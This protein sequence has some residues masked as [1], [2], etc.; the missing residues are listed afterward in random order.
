[1]A[2]TWKP[3]ASRRQAIVAGL[4]AV[5]LGWGSVPPGA[6]EADV[7]GPQ[8]FPLVN[9][10]GAAL[11]DAEASAAPSPTTSPGPVS[12]STTDPDVAPPPSPSPQASG[13]PTRAAGPRVMLPFPSP[14]ANDGG[15]PTLASPAPLASQDES[16]GATLL[17]STPTTFDNFN[18][19]VSSG[20]GTASSGNWWSPWSSCVDN[21]LLVNGQAGSITG[22]V[23]PFCAT[24]AA[25]SPRPWEAPRWAMTGKFRTP[26]SGVWAQLQLRH[27]DRRP[28]AVR[29]PV[30]HVLRVVV[31]TSTPGIFIGADSG[32]YDDALYPFAP[33]TWYSFSWVH[34]WGEQS[35]AKVW[36]SSQSAPRAW[37][38]E[39]NATAD[40]F[41]QPTSRQLMVSNRG[42]ATALVD[43]FAFGDAPLLQL[44]PPPPGTD[45]NPPFDDEAT[46]GD[47]VN[48]LTGTLSLSRLDVAIAGRGPAISFA[49]AYNSND[50]RTTTLG[51]GWTHTYNMRLNDP[52]DGSE[53][54]ILVGPQGRS[55]RYQWSGSAFVAPAGSETTLT[56]NIDESYTATD[57]SQSGWEFGADGRLTSIRDRYGN[58]SALTYDTS[59]RLAT[60]SDPAGRGLLT[61]GYT[62]NL[63]TSV[64]DW[65]SPART[66]TYQYDTNGRLWKAFDREGKTTTYTYDGTSQRLATVTDANGH[67]TLTTTYDAS[68]RAA[69]QQDAR[70]LLTGDITTF[71][72]IANP[73]G[74]RVTT[75]T[76]P[77]TSYEPALHPTLVDTYDANGRLTSR[78]TRPSSTETLTQGF[79]YDA[80]GNRTSA[81]D[82]RGATTNFCYDVD[83]AGSPIAGGAAN[84]T[85][86]IG[87]PPV[88]GASRPVTLFAYDAR[89]NMIQ[90]VAPKGVPSGQTVTCSTNLSAITTYATDV[91]YDAAGVNLL[92][93]TTR[94][95]D[96]DTSAKT[97]VTKYEYG[98]AANP[99]LVTRVIPPR[100]NTG[101]TPDYTYAMTLTYDAT[102]SQAGMPKDTTDPLGNK[103]SYTYDAVGRLVSSVDALGNAAGG[104]PAEHTTQL[105]YDREDRLRFE[106]S[107]APAPGGSPIVRE[108]RYDEVGRPVVR[109]AP[110]GQVTTY[111]YDER[112]SLSQVKES[113][114]A[115]TDPAS[116]PAAVTTT[117]YTHDAGGN[118]TRVTR[119]KGDGTYE[120]ATDS[121]YDGR[122]LL[123]TETQYP[124]WPA[125]SGPLVTA[126]TFDPAG[127]PLTVV[128]ALGQG[129]THG[130][131]AL[132]R[133]ISV[134]Y[135]APGTADVGYAYD[136]NGNRT[137]MTDGTGTT[138]YAY[139]EA[140]RLTSVT[141]PGPKTL[142]YRYDLDGNRTKIVYP[143]GT[144]V[145]YAFDK[146]GRMI[147][148]ADW[149]S[150]SVAYT[151]FADGLVE[152]A[153]NPNATV[154]SY[155]YDNA[156]RLV[157]IRHGGPAGQVLDRL[158]YTL[159]PA[160]TVTGLAN[161]SFAAQFARPDGPA[162]SNG[163]WSG[164]FASINEV[165]PN[166]AT[167]LASPAGPTTTNYYEVSLGD[168]DPPG[169]RAGITV[170][171]RYAKSGNDAGQ[172]I[173]LT[174]ELRQG[175]T[176][177]AS[178]AHPNIPGAAGSG[179]QAGS[180]I[181]TTAQANAITNFAD[182]RL[183]FRPSAAGGGQ[184][185]SAEI[186]WAEL[187]V[188]GPGDPASQ[189]SYTY[190]R[191]ERLTGTTG[192]SGVRGYTYDPVGNR[193][194]KVEGATTTS[195]YD[196]ADRLTAVGATSVAVDAAGNLVAKGADTF[197]FDAA[198]RLTGATV[199]GTN[200]AYAYDGDG[201]RVSRQ[202]GTGPV[203]RYVS[204]VNAPLPIVV[205][206]GSR[207]YIYGLGLAYS[208][209][210]SGIEVYHTD[211]LGSVREL[212]NG[213]GAVTA[214]YRT[215]EWG[216]GTQATGSSSQPF[217][218]TGEPRDGT[219]LTYLRARYYD[220][221]IGLFTSRD[222][223]PGS[224]AAPG[225]LN[226]YAYVD[227]NPT[228]RSD[229]SGH[230]G[231]DVIV[232]VG[233]IIF[234]LGSLAFG[235]PKDREG[236][237]LALGADVGGAAIPCATGLGVFARAGIKVVN[238]GDKILEWE[239]CDPR[240]S[241]DLRS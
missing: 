154:A 68:G 124:S 174:V 6:V 157:E 202:V 170:R 204:D 82:L 119:A 144:A 175:A 237:L 10:G 135:A 222:P 71:D 227:G 47:P 207:T 156:R 132:G 150:R 105:S 158:T 104:V 137:S 58:T 66:V 57:K 168:A 100:G 26:S 173:N 149:A 115:W 226:R 187:Q 140:D 77:A 13:E 16:E 214:T 74:T 160:G 136:P 30:G 192:A 35:R 176:V 238:T 155:A 12:T 59:G 48:T 102:G 113:P 25:T 153:T 141:S 40:Q 61:L 127:S 55:D 209:T 152:T 181:L 97:A 179:W 70:G 54:V 118:V 99:G 93:V 217:G 120:R 39:R 1:M 22:S 228:T 85:R 98:D 186:S 11:R 142:G 8:D 145:T 172:T 218:Y 165:T 32:Y 143:A 125:T 19:T 3:Q 213:A 148:L 117:E 225:T 95:T 235:P 24:N 36:P 169:D 133:L 206:D 34:V 23:I 29:C 219:G 72:Y 90:T 180:F 20:W 50:T 107:P 134:D 110:N 146:A 201:T 46:A 211:R 56:R 43:D 2:R 193:L 109:I 224:A 33:D 191:L 233:F 87:P 69:T 4:L 7:K 88:P 223:W 171:Y 112:N 195:V 27:G 92:A 185:R 114:L 44:V 67:V 37:L 220:P 45:H 163:A 138:T 197:A 21:M 5:V 216:I 63:L 73:D 28:D 78:V 76:T 126:T 116:P 183:R 230:C 101:P 151:Y 161:G 51:P 147:S 80:A 15:F 182:L 188:P 139:D 234:D 131:D 9:P 62:S 129:T 108:T 205:D 177:I 232:D 200:E 122:G 167:L 189:I 96:P 229:P 240:R 121:A 221:S 210:A 196:R 75:V 106:T 194:T 94:F 83:Y 84:L 199:A 162:G 79:T 190:D 49:R 14:S 81:T 89:N 164:T 159:D 17:A 91:T 241:R 178:A 103:S 203:T 239:E 198:N 60:I 65:A 184:K 18:R 42:S 130:Y 208:V 128:D 166:D 215:D 53:D 123:R 86:R 236:N 231:V 111:A 64:T 38:V 31:G 212:T 52:G 41:Q